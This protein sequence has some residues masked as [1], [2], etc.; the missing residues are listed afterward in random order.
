MK[1][2]KLM[3]NL[4]AIGAV[5]A[6]VLALSACSDDSSSSGSTS[7]FTGDQS[8]YA[9][10]Q[11]A[12][13]PVTS[14]DIPTA[15]IS[16]ASS[17][18]GKTVYY[19]PITQQAPLFGV[20]ATAL[21]SALGNV[22][23]NVQ[24]CNGNGTPT[25]ISNCVDQAVGAKAGAIITDGIYYGMAK[26]SLDAA[27]AAG[28][29][30]IVNNSREFPAATASK[31]LYYLDGPDSEQLQTVAKWTIVDSNS[32]ANVLLNE[33]QDGPVPL[34]YSADAQAIWKACSGCSVTVNQVSTA[35]FAQVTPST[36]AALLSNPKVN[37]VVPEFEQYLQA[38]QA[39]VQQANMIS[40][41]KGAAASGSL[42][43]LQALASDGWLQALTAQDVVYQ[44]WALA[45]ASLRIM[46]GMDMPTYTIPMR[47][48]TQQNVGSLTLTS[49]AQA[50]GEWFG[51]TTFGDSYKT[52]WGVN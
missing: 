34:A 50:S 40:S 17:L 10:V 51:P 19:I 43:G 6:A 49:D 20:T 30:V 23:V 15:K 2:P 29:P 35:N 8:I 11:A 52:L 24:V 25:D 26:N 5:T 21:T 28:V 38:T 41:T 45:D 37:Y 22:G 31:T 36:S 48:F 1:K 39:G 42:G 32:N 46:L 4:V 47:L 3:R 12:M 7:T 13:Q 33:V 44:G 27:Q 18:K 14:Y 9:A 16:N